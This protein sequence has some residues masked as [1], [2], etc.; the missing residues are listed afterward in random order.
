VKL[1]VEYGNPIIEVKTIK[2]QKNSYY[3]SRY[4]NDF[5][6]AVEKY[7]NQVA[8]FLRRI[9]R[10]NTKIQKKILNNWSFWFRI[11]PLFYGCRKKLIITKSFKHSTTGSTLD[12]WRKSRIYIVPAIKLRG[13]EIV[14]HVAEDSRF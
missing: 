10:K 4:W 8:F 9:L 12:V 7:I 11:L 2:K 3:W 1:K 14:L 6:E 13:T 5:E